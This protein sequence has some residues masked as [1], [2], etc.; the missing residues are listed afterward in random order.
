MPP[1]LRID[2]N[3]AGPAAVGI[4][5]P[6]GQRTTVIVRPRA[7]K[8]DLLPVRI[9]DGVRSAFC[10]FSRD[11]A[12]GVARLLHRDLSATAATGLDPFVLFSQPK[13]SSFQ[14]GIKGGEFYWI[15]CAR[16]PGRSY[17][18]VE[19]ASEAEAQASVQ[20]IGKFLCPP[21]DANQEVYFNTQHFK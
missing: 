11:E 13:A 14:I 4:L 20:D 10:Q 9:E 19:F 21:P 17:E 18:P 5:V 15:V 7:L 1:F 12:A 8:W 2:Q 3:R 6:P 16:T